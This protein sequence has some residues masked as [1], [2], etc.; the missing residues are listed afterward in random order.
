MGESVVEATLTKW[1]KEVGDT[2]EVED[3][4][5]EIA[6]DKVDSDVTSEVSGILIEKKFLENDVVKVGDVMAIIQ[7]DVDESINE[8]ESEHK[9]GEEKQIK[10]LTLPNQRPLNC[11]TICQNLKVYLKL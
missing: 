9:R 2:I 3:T 5:V 10:K 8:A 7:T 1:L 11:L 4:V 6:T